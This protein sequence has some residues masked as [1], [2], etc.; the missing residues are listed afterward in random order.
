LAPEG[1]AFLTSWDGAVAEWAIMT[2]GELFRQEA[3]AR[4]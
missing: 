1:F 3:F 4:A 2:T